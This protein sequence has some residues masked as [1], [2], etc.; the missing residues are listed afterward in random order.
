MFYY[1][2]I[3]QTVHR[4][5]QPPVINHPNGSQCSCNVTESELSGAMTIDTSDLK[6][7]QIYFVKGQEIWATDLE[8]CQCWQVI[9]LPAPLGKTLVCMQIFTGDGRPSYPIK[10]GLHSTYTQMDIYM[11]I[12]TNNICIWYLLQTMP[13]VFVDFKLYSGKLYTGIGIIFWTGRKLFSSCH[14]IV[15][16]TINTTH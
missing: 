7:P 1:S 13:N 4:I 15:N 16:R 12:H 2:I 6:K 9:I 10:K 8:A 3:N 14:F 11:Y 5:L